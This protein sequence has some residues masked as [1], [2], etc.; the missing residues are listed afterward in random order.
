MIIT[1]IL[2]IAVKLTPLCYRATHVNT[3]ILILTWFTLCITTVYLT[4]SGRSSLATIF[5]YIIAYAVWVELF[6]RR[7][8]MTTITTICYA[9]YR[10]FPSW[11][12]LTA[13]ITIPGELK[14]FLETSFE[15]YASLA[16]TTYHDIIEYIHSFTSC[17]PPLLG[18]FGLKTQTPYCEFYNT[19][20]GISPQYDTSV[21]MA[22]YSVLF[23]ILAGTII[24]TTSPVLGWLYFANQWISKYLDTHTQT[25][26][27][28]EVL[29]NIF[30]THH[31]DP[32]NIPKEH[33]HPTAARNRSTASKII[34]D[35]IQTVGLKPYSEQMSKSD[36][37]KGIEGSRTHY[38]AKDV[39]TPPSSAL[40][41]ENHA[42]VIIDVD[43]YLDMPEYLATIPFVPVFLYTCQ[44]CKA[45]NTTNN[46][47]YM[48]SQNQL[49]YKVT[50]GGEYTHE[51]WNYQQDFVTAD[52][53]IVFPWQR[54]VYEIFRR[55]IDEDHCVILIMPIKQITSVLIN[56]PW[57]VQKSPLDR[58]KP[59][60][61]HALEGEN[62]E[63]TTVTSFSEKR[64]VSIAID[65]Q[66]ISVQIPAEDLDA[67]SNIVKNSSVKLTASA[68]A[69]AMSDNDITNGQLQLI[70]R[71]VRATIKTPPHPII[72]P[73]IREA[74][75]QYLSKIFSIPKTS[76][77]PFMNPLM[78][79]AYAPVRDEQSDIACVNGRI[80]KFTTTQTKLSGPLIVAV[81]KYV[82]LIIKDP[83]SLIP[84]EL[85]TVY[86]N[87]SKPSQ[88]QI[89]ERSEFGKYKHHI[90]S[91]QKAE[92]Y[93][94]TTDPRNISTFCGP[95][96]RDLS[97]YMYAGAE[98]LKTKDWY[99]FGKTPKK[100]TEFIVKLASTSNIVL[101]SDGSRWDGH[102][103][104]VFRYLD[105]VVLLRL[106]QR[107]YHDELF[108]TYQSSYCNVGHTT[109]GVHYAQGASQGSGDPFTSF[110]NSIRN[111]F[112]SFVANHIETKLYNLNFK[113][114]VGGDDNITFD[115]QPESLIKAARMVGQEFE[116]NIVQRGKPFTF[117]SRQFTSQIWSG[118]TMSYCDIKRTCAK[119]HLT[120]NLPP[121]VTPVMK[122]VE[123]ARAYYLTDKNTPIIGDFVTKVAALTCDFTTYIPELDRNIASF[124][125]KYDGCDQFDNNIEEN[126]DAT[127]TSIEQWFDY[128]GF[129]EHLTHC[130]TL[131]SLL[132]LPNFDSRNI[133]LPQTNVII[134][135]ELFSKLDKT[136]I[137]P[138]PILNKETN[139]EV[140]RIADTFA[141]TAT[142]TTSDVEKMVLQPPSTTT[143]T[144]STT[145]T[146]PM[147]PPTPPIRYSDKMYHYKKTMDT[148]NSK[149]GALNQYVILDYG[150]GDG[151][152][153]AEYRT[154]YGDKTRK[155]ICF[156]PFVELPTPH[157]M[158]T[159]EIIAETEGQE[160]TDIIFSS[161]I[162]HITNV[163]W[164][165]EKVMKKIKMHPLCVVY[166]RDHNVTTQI[167]ADDLYTM[168]KEKFHD[169][170]P[171]SYAPRA[172]LLRL[173]THQGFTQIVGSS[174]HPK[175]KNPTHLFHVAI[176]RPVKK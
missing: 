81:H 174:N 10:M 50:G 158:N 139:A 3:P 62:V 35:V 129:K 19:Y 109:F 128:K 138:K 18:L 24:I 161:S 66:L 43:Y 168:H 156:D 78:L 14:R 72:Y 152:A 37:N 82:D 104:I 132:T 4:I 89:L 33:T 148:A 145:T 77:I 166:I 41:T 173:F 54:R 160:I 159:D 57:L 15:Y 59:N 120:P 56:I 147:R 63:V 107:Q 11:T 84:A 46:Y 28:Y 113:T 108:G 17:P 42:I 25:Y 114:M 27:S 47:S 2:A 94:K 123:K 48:F 135:N 130:H 71:Y 88:R 127:I 103:S 39:K 31:V 85:D 21:Y 169:V 49:H 176:M 58:F 167:V 96:K 136:I 76:M 137:P 98:W 102:V 40:I 93:G 12:T 26:T 20:Y 29:K 7:R 83:H 70:T 143:T 68:T 133:P 65:K 64:L 74:N 126:I 99:A 142:R 91:F 34:Q 44:P 97:R 86:D 122:L 9:A 23:I 172:E 155:Y 121:N 149:R 165:Y 119:F 150:S 51:I 30:L 112:V 101:D 95:I 117:L 6:N 164:I 134:N 131:E 61:V 157:C 36:Y 118:S 100:I 79:T 110:L 111:H 8:V 5:T 171:Q 87:Q 141:H 115:M 32:V 16:H 1:I 146:I 140:K 53:T 45:T 69:T 60:T 67:V 154:Y 13:I 124:W 125:S 55:D 170:T 144:T 106:F 92:A 75:Y 90:E 80:N 38:W 175:D 153:S 105:L 52:R 73:A 162:H 22:V 163:D 116:V 151:V